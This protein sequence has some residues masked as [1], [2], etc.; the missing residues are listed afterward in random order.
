MMLLARYALIIPAIIVMAFYAPMLFDVAFGERVQKTHIFYSPV[1]KKFIWLDKLI[2]P[3]EEGLEDVHHAQ[4]VQM[5]Q[6]GKRY[7]RQEFEKLLP[8]IYYRNMEIWGLLPLELEGKTFD[9]NTIKANRQVIEFKPRQIDDRALKDEVYPLIE[10]VPGSARLIFPED[11]FRLGREFEFIN[12]DYNR[13]DEKVT[14]VFN[15][16]LK[17]AG[18]Q[19]PGRLA[20]GKSTI[21]KPFDEGVFLVDADGNVFHVKRVNGKPRVIKTPI[22]PALNVRSIKVNENRRKEFYGLALTGDKRLH[23]ISYD[24]YRLIPLPLESYD[25]ETMDFK[26]IINP[27]YRTAT[28][29]DDET[30]RAVVMDSQYRPLDKYQHTMPGASLTMAQSIFNSLTPFR[31][32]LE[33]PTQG[34]F[35]LEIDWHGWRSWISIAIGL[36][37]FVFLAYRRRSKGP[38]LVMDGILVAL[39]GLY[40]LVAVSILPPQKE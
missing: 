28:Y 18:F 25:P 22:D 14:Q 33:D 3:E 10:S 15:D 32:N 37:I 8:F 38:A 30:I 13:R 17:E 5:D 35:S 39:T 12:A 2:S 9:K 31:L 1:L 26:L 7:T 20:A 21:L 27:L 19:F 40:G 24:N 4:F 29:S 11:R 23:L 6:D 34:Y 16:A 36:A